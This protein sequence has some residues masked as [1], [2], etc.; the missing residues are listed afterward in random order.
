MAKS[1]GQVLLA[2]WTASLQKRDKK[3]AAISGNFAD[4][5]MD[6][7]MG[8]VEYEEAEDLMAEAIKAHYPGASALKNTWAA[9]KQFYSGTSE[10]EFADGWR[11]II[12]DKGWSEFWAIYQNPAVE[13]PKMIGGMSPEEFSKQ[14]KIAAS[15]VEVNPL[16]A[17][18]KFL[19]LVE[20]LK[21]RLTEMGFDPEI[22][23][24]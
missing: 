7:N 1:K 17:E 4:F 24:G 14:Q 11:K 3:A 15:F 16:E 23:N 10:K 18:V 5:V 21:K 20:D 22:D 19:N 12:A 2:M 9:Q 13:K 8:G 6:M